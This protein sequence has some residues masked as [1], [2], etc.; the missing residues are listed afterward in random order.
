MYLF[1]SGENSVQYTA[2]SAAAKKNMQA[3]ATWMGT[4]QKKDILVSGEPLQATGKQVNGTKKSVGHGPFTE[5]KE[6]ERVSGFLIV[7]AKNIDEAVELS[8][9]CPIF[10]ENGKVEVRP[11]QKMEM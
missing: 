8:K 10:E 6:K 2:N 1:R 4:L 5:G 11:I 9:D 3:W 7:K